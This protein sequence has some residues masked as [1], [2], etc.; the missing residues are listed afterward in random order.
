M[1]KIKSLTLAGLSLLGA[2]FIVVDASVAADT[3][4]EQY[5]SS[6][7]RFLGLK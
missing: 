3:N 7:M 2:N 4:P 6:P 5:F 1:D